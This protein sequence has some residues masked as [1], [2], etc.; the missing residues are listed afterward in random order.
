MRTRELIFAGLLLL[1]IAG[2]V[3]GF[4]LNLKCSTTSLSSLA[5]CVNS[6]FTKTQTD[7]NSLQTQITTLTA[8]VTAL[9]KG[10][11]SNAVLVGTYAIV[12]TGYSH[13]NSGGTGL[14]VY[15]ELQQNTLILNS[16]LSFTMDQN[17]SE[18]QLQLATTSTGQSSSTDL[19]SV[20]PQ[21]VTSVTTTITPT[22]NVGSAPGTWSLAGGILTLTPSSGNPL[23]FTVA[24]GGKVLMTVD[25]AGSVWLGFKTP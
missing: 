25:E 3:S 6:N 11:L 7:L 4:T 20:A 8:K 17:K 14:N 12:V 19:V 21:V 10:T 23:S 15:S 5:S 22:S 24:D 1:L 18:S 13:D 9:Q 16:D 2:E